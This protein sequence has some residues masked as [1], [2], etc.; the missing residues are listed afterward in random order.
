MKKDLQRLLKKKERQE[1]QQLKQ[2][3]QQRS[4]IKEMEQG[5]KF[6]YESVHSDRLSDVRMLKANQIK[7]EIFK[8]SKKDQE[9]RKLEKREENLLK[10]LKETHALQQETLIQIQDIF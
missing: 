5:L 10:R 2:K 1:I 8:I 3:Q 4:Q 7:A 9:A 6:L